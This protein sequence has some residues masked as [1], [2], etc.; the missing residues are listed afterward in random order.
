MIVDGTEKAKVVLDMIPKQSS[1]I[2]RGLREKGP[3]AFLYAINAYN[4]LG[5][6]RALIDSPRNFRPSRKGQL[7]I[8]R[9]LYLF[10]IPNDA[11][12]FQMPLPEIASVGV[13]REPDV[14]ISLHSLGTRPL[15]N[16]QILRAP[17]I[18]TAVR[19]Q[20]REST[21]QLFGLCH[22]NSEL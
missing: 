21:K 8:P 4:N 16:I 20:N 11:S 17:S 7:A 12:A 18:L 13:R 5:L 1:T 15:S 19:R 14:S 9:K 3:T 10:V 2:Q 22:T 6:S